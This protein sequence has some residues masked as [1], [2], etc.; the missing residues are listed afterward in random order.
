MIP[1]HLNYE[2]L[3]I[4]TSVTFGRQQMKEVPPK[5]FPVP[6][7]WT[8]NGDGKW[9]KSCA[10]GAFSCCTHARISFDVVLRQRISS[11]PIDGLQLMYTWL[12][13][14]IM[15]SALIFIITITC[16]EKCYL[17]RSKSLPGAIL[18][19]N[20]QDLESVFGENSREGTHLADHF[21]NV[22]GTKSVIVSKSNT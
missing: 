5:R 7:A 17:Q 15:N 8:H 9:A 19:I 4:L 13:C 20:V 3:E 14:E 21:G 1:T 2:G 11:Y 6:F 18:P 10:F 22:G 12:S 16:R